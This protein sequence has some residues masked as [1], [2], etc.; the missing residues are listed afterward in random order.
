MSWYSW[1]TGRI[2]SDANDFTAV[3]NGRP[4]VAL[5]VGITGIVGTSLANLLLKP[6]APGGPWKMYGVARRAQPKWFVDRQIEYVQ[7]DVLDGADVQ[8]KIAPLKDVTHLFWVVWVS[9]GSEEN[10]CAD[11]GKM[12]QNVLDALLPNAGK[13]QH[14]VLQTGG[15]H[16]V[17]TSSSTWKSH[18]NEPPFKEDMPRLPSPNFYYTLE[19]ILFDTVKREGVSLT[20]SV[21]RPNVIFGFSPC[22]LMNILGSLAVYACICKHEGLPF[23]FPGNNLTW[24]QLG[25]VSDA[26]L[27][28]EQELWAALDSSAKNQAFNI[29]N[30]DVF[31]YK[32]VWSLLAKQFDLAVPDYN[33]QP[34]SLREA[35][36][37]NGP[38]WDGIVQKHGLVPTKLDEI[39][40]WRYVDGVLNT[41]LLGISSMNKSKELGFL[42]FRN[43][44][45]SVGHWI[46]K[47]RQERLIP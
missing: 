15:K 46:A 19:D 39:A 24:E 20:W 31:N 11:N 13:L 41:S 26:D 43:T 32:R 5:V 2:R 44:E 8:T 16:Y 21:H 9:R 1:W 4:K 25:D 29:S 7:C 38:V 30:G 37:D 14:V 23:L 27:V 42:G 6:D 35:M 10:N 17:G 36:K 45:A 3:G 18:G 33:G 40:N 28:A 22:S 34:T 12:F 47:M